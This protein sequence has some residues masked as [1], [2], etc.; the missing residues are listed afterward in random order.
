MEE[1]P[2]KGAEEA[3]KSEMKDA[4]QTPEGCIIKIDHHLM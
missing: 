1:G 3:R 2:L 4:D